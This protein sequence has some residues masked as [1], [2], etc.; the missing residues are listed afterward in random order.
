MGRQRESERSDKKLA[1]RTK[2][3]RV[4]S[5]FSYH[6]LWYSLAGGVG[7]GK[8]VYARIPAIVVCIH[9]SI[10]YAFDLKLRT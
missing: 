6:G 4:T 1:S 10:I 7:T 9:T 3:L 2:P 8:A 5:Q